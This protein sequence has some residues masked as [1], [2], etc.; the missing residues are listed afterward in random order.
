MRFNGDLN[1]M[2]Y[3]PSY[4]REAEQR[5]QAVWGDFRSMAMVFSMGSDTETALATNDLVFHSL[6]RELPEAR[7]VSMAPLFPSAA[8]RSRTRTMDALLERNEG[9]GRTRQPFPRVGP[10]GVL[11]GRFF[12]VHGGTPRIAAAHNA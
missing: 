1:S 2:S 4:L 11:V 3:V 10:P 6:R 5:I 12:A 8:T 7:V 9:P